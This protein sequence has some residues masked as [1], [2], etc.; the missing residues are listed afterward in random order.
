ML[1]TST[2]WA[3]M[4]LLGVSALRAG[5]PPPEEGLRSALQLAE[6]NRG[7]EAVAALSALLKQHPDYADAYY[8]RGREQ[9]KLQE[10]KA[11]LADFDRYVE[12]RPAA[13]SRQWERGIACYYAGEFKRGAQQFELYQT[14]HDQ[15]VENS[16][17]R[18]LC[19]AAREG[20]ETAR[21]DM[22][23]IEGDRR[24][25]LMEIYNL[26]RGT[27]TPDDVFAAAQAGQ[28]GQPSQAELARRLFYAHLY[29]GLYY[30]SQGDAERAKPHLQKAAGEFRI[31]HYMG[32]VARVHAAQV[33]KRAK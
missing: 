23:P 10:V 32:D 31:A 33:S 20:A 2:L 7:T 19:V 22:L 12:L 17:W 28:A 5:P 29:V 4:L 21:K 8:W 27:K 13:E 15:D 3:A 6:E 9:F 16:V 30:D 24:V 1:R 26:Y 14:Y 18:Y 11:S 25:P